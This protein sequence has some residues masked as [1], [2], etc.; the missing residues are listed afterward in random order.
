MA[1]NMLRIATSVPN[2]GRFS[3]TLGFSPGPFKN[4][5]NDA[6]PEQL[7]RECV[8][9]RV[10]VYTALMRHGFPT[11][12]HDIAGALRDSAIVQPRKCFERHPSLLTFISTETR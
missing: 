5:I 3:P 10:Q 8:R 7:R 6:L 1:F 11:G 4:Q 9:P 2:R 12:R